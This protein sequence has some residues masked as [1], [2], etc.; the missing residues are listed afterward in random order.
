VIGPA[1][2]GRHRG[3]PHLGLPHQAAQGRDR[4]CG[5]D[6]QRRPRQEPRA[7]RTRDHRERAA[8]TN[9]L[10]D[11]SGHSQLTGIPDATAGA[12]EVMREQLIPVGRGGRRQGRERLADRDGLYLPHRDHP[13]HRDRAGRAA[14]PPRL[15]VDGD[16]ECLPPA[17]NAALA[18]PVTAIAHETAASAF[19][20]YGVDVT[21]APSSHIHEILETNIVTLNLLDPAAAP[22]SEPANAAAEVI[23]VLIATPLRATRTS[24]P[25]RAR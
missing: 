9:P 7:A 12:L 22:S 21:L 14:V 13:Q 10:V 20:E 5:G 17:A 4:L 3:R 8:L 18:G 2:R 23:K 16:T 1:A 15:L 6:H 19:N 25:A 24:P 11:S